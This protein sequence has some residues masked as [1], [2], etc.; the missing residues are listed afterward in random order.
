MNKRQTDKPGDETAEA[1]SEAAR[2]WYQENKQAVDAYNEL[3][4]KYGLFSDGV[5]TF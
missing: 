1:L 3:V 2:Q 5:R 4:E